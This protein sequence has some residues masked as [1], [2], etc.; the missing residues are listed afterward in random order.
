M[1]S[2]EIELAGEEDAMTF[3]GAYSKDRGLTI[4][5]LHV[6]LTSSDLDASARW[7]KD[8]YSFD[9]YA[10]AISPCDLGTMVCREAIVE[11]GFFSGELYVRSRTPETFPYVGGFLHGSKLSAPAGVFAA[12]IKDG[13]VFFRFSDQDL[14]IEKCSLAFGS[15]RLNL[16]GGFENWKKPHGH[17]TVDGEALDF[18]DIFTKDHETLFHKNLKDDAKESRE[19]SFKVTAT[20]DEGRWKSFPYKNLRLNGLVTSQAF[21]V[22][23]FSFSSGPGVYDGTAVIPFGTLGTLLL[24]SAYTDHASTV[25]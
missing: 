9:L 24:Y 4:D 13:E 19:F 2:W 25:S 1:R 6:G 7:N 18:E 14:T 15:S 8:G 3:E 20:V 11:E 17:L 16:T 12:P 5:K 10:K 22:S 23:Y 21:D